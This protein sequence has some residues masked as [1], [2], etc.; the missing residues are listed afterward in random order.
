MN[1]A[2]LLGVAEAVRVPSGVKVAVDVG[3]RVGDGISVAVGRGVAVDVTVGVG[4]SRSWFTT[5][6][7]NIADATVNESKR[8]ARISHCQPAIIWARRVR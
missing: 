6:S 5:G 8:S 4:D 3:V 2:V 1:V 7:P